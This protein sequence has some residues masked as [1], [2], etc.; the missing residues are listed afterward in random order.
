MRVTDKILRTNLLSNLAYSSERLYNAETK[1]LTNKKI[2]KPSDNP[3]DTINALSIRTRLEEIVQYQRN[4]SRINNL[5]LNTETIVSQLSDMFQRVTA[6]VV[7][8]ASDSYGPND[9]LSIANEV[10]QLLEQVFNASNTKSEAVYIFA[11]TSNDVAPYSAIRN[12]EGNITEVKTFGSGGDIVRVLG[13]GITLKSNINGEDLFERGDNIFNILIKIRDDLIAG[14][15]DSL[16]EDLNVVY[17][18]SE[19][20]VNT[21]AVLGART[22]RVEAAEARALNNQI[23]FTEYLSNTEDVDADVA[24]MNY[25][26]ELLALQTSLQVGARLMQPRLI[27]FLR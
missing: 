24:I 10:N 15:S 21:L 12:A 6:L 2:N 7:Q 27:D 11:G 8:G 18:V 13:E 17:D 19:K 14:N 3:V 1:V 23:N 26:T 16:R 22:N 4:M 20:I 9:R 25:Q 5:I